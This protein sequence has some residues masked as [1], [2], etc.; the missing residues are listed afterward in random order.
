[1]FEGCYYQQVFGTAM[2]SPVSAV[3]A[4]LVMEDVEQRALPSVP[5]S[6]SFWKRFVDDVISAV[7]RN[8]SDIL[9]Q[10]LNSIEPSIQ[11]T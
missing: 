3:I 7:S 4:N 10:H 8:E 9:M 1:V 5:V 2:A 11:L 6:P